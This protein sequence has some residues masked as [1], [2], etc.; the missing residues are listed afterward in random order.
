MLFPTHLDPELHSWLKTP[1]LRTL[2]ATVRAA[3][4]EARVVGGA[5]RDALMGRPVGDIDLACTLPPDILSDV[6]KAAGIK[7]VPT[8]IDHGTL[9]A[10][11]DGTGYE[12]TTLRRDMETDGRHATVRFTDDWQADA[13]RRDFTFNAIYLDESGRLYDLADGA[14]DCAARRV[15]FIGDADE[16]LREDVLRL[17]RFFRFLAQMA[18]PGHPC[19]PDPEGLAACQRAKERLGTLSAERVWKELSRLLIAPDPAPVLELMAREGILTEIL[20]EAVHFDRLARLIVLEATHQIIPE[21]VRR[22][23]T[24]MTQGHEMLARRLHFSTAQ[25]Q[26][27]VALGKIKLPEIL[28]EKEI[29]QMLYDEGR[30]AVRDALLLRLADGAE[31]QPTFWPL[32][33]GW[34]K[35]VFPVRGQDLLALDFTPG[36]AMGETLHAIESWWRAQDFKPGRDACIAQVKERHSSR[37][38][39]CTSESRE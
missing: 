35:P 34:K 24:L 31:D 7:V 1:G 38:N 33:K 19:L 2:W 20:P 17:L 30:E 6:L 15:R 13:A 9:I 37:G 16:R 11:I 10:V 4:G 18:E 3:G 36:P 14:T 12:I 23:A 28:D 8:G 21:P 29:R 26:G 22:L 27:L 32:I 25:R 39:S 5:V